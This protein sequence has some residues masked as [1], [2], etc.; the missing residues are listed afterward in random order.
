MFFPTL[1]LRGG[2]TEEILKPPFYIICHT[3]YSWFCW[4]FDINFSLGL[5]TSV[6]P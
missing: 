1:L 5:W 6:T 2:D 3:P 4:K